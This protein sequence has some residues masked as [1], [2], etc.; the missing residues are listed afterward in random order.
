[1]RKVFRSVMT[2]AWD[3]FQL[4]KISRLPGPE[5]KAT[6]EELRQ[7]HEEIKRVGPLIEEAV[8]LPPFSDGEL[9]EPISELKERE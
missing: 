2:T 3:R 1:V 4:L 8:G 7:I 6:P 5:G 9:P